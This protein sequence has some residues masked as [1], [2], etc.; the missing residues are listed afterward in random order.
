MGMTVL[1]VGYTNT[2]VSQLDRGVSAW[3]G[4]RFVFNIAQLK[5][6]FMILDIAEMQRAA[7]NRSLALQAVL[8]KEYID[9][10]TAATL[11]NIQ[12]QYSANAEQVVR[13]WWNLADELVMFYADGYCNGCGRAPRHMGYPAWWL[14][15]V[16]YSDG[17]RT[18]TADA[19]N[20]VV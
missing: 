12:A 8:D 4:F 19:S 16:N 7:E 6:K 1:P 10:P 20:I 15:A 17:P 3:Q 9:N 5:F 2:T 13:D 11:D 18:P 14:T